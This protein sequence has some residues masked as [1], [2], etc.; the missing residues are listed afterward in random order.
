MIHGLSIALYLT[1]LSE[2]LSAL[3]ND[4]LARDVEH[5]QTQQEIRR[6]CSASL[7][8]LTQEDVPRPHLAHEWKAELAWMRRTWDAEMAAYAE[9]FHSHSSGKLEA[10]RRVA[11]RLWALER[12][13]ISSQRPRFWTREA[14]RT[15]RTH[16]ALRGNS[17]LLLDHLPYLFLPL[18]GD[19]RFGLKVVL[20][21]DA[22]N[23]ILIE[24]ATPREIRTMR[25]V[26]R[27]APQLGVQDSEAVFAGRLNHEK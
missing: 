3:P 15:L 10:E 23:R 9:R 13:F 4:H 2:S 22:H 27:H 25:W 18:E 17:P 19:A 6:L 12:D 5:A 1:A 7:A 26:N 20:P 21:S 24:L 14:Q 11:N 8:R 16:M